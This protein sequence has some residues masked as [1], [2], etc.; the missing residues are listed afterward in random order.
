MKTLDL[1]THEFTVDELLRSARTE[2]V[3]VRSKDGDE[4]V[5]E[6]A[7]AFEREV[8]EL[9]NS[10]KFMSFLA[11]RSKEPGS[12]SLEEIQQRLSRTTE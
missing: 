11:Q 2:A 1:G 12:V 3:R 9:A 7:D 5:I 6:A 8:A 10:A 4:F